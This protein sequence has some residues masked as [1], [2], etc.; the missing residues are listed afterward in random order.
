[1]ARIVHYKG[2]YYDLGTSNT[3]FLQLAN[4]LKT[5][6]I[7]NCYFMLEIYDYSL[8]NVDP[9]ACDKDGKTTLTKDQISRIITECKRNPWY[10]LREVVRITEP[11]NPNGTPYRANRGNIA[12]AWCILHNIDSWLCLPRQQGKTMSA[13]ALELWIYNF[14]TTNS[15]FIFVNKDGDNAKENLRRIGAMI[16]ALPEYMRFLSIM[17]EDG[18]VTKAKKNAT[19]YGH[20][21]TLNKIITKSRASSYDGALSIA[22]GLTAPILHFD[23]PEFTPFI[24]VIVKNS[25]STFETAHRKSIEN[26]SVSARVFTCTPKQPLG[27]NSSNRIKKNSFNCG[28]LSLGS[29]YY[30]L[31]K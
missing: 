5:L 31:Y 13:L 14:G 12:Q 6:G 3:S 21:I 27:V 4:D 29:I 30:F 19:E 26:G 7:S 18:K 11:G 24:D 20:P 25:V 22:R 8:V 17:T 15:T 23:E 16:E 28:K 9:H 2:K 1:M 10:F